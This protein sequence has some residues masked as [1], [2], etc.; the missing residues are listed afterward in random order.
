[1]AHPS[2]TSTNPTNGGL[3]PSAA[4][5]MDS[6]RAKGVGAD[7]AGPATMSAK[8]P[9]APIA[10]VFNGQFLFDDEL[11][12]ANDSAFLR[13]YNLSSED[14]DFP[15]LRQDQFPSALST[16][17]SALDLAPLSQMSPRQHR[18]DPSGGTQSTVS[19]W[20]HTASNE[21]RRNVD[22]SVNDLT[23]S[24][25]ALSI[26]ESHRL[27]PGA[28]RMSR[29]APFSAPGAELFDQE[30]R[31]ARSMGSAAYPPINMRSSTNSSAASSASFVAS[32]PTSVH[33]IST[34][35]VPMLASSSGALNMDSS[36]PRRESSMENAV[37]PVSRFPNAD[38]RLHSRFHSREA[39]PP[40][41][42]SGHST[43]LPNVN[44]AMATPNGQANN[45]RTKPARQ[46]FG[47]DGVH[48]LEDASKRRTD[49]DL[50]TM[51]LENLR[52]ELSQLCKD[53]YGCR[54]LQK[55][56][57]EN[58]RGQCDLIFQETFPYF[59]E[60]MTDPFGNYLCQKLL[61]YCTDAQ[62]DQI[63]AAIADDLVTISLNMH[64]TRAVQKT[65]DFISTPAQTQTIIAALSRNVVT[66]IKDLNGNHVIQK[67]LNRLEAK[68]SQFIYDAVAQKCMDVAT[69]RHG[70]C[71]MQRCIDHATDAQRHQ[72]VHEITRHALSLVQD[73]FG[74][75]VVQY[76][77]D[78]NEAPFTEALTKQFVHHVCLL[79]AQKFSSNVIEKCIRV[80]SPTSRKYLI[81]ELIDETKLEALLRDSFANY[82]VQTSLDY[83]EPAQRT[84]LVN[85]IRPIL[86]A[87]RNTPYGK[88]I[89]SKLQREGTEPGFTNRPPRPNGT[90]S[91][92]MVGGGHGAPV[93]RGHP[94]NLPIGSRGNSHG[95]H[96]HAAP[97]GNR[98]KP[99]YSGYAMPSDTPMYASM[100]LYAP[101]HTMN[102][103]QPR[104]GAPEYVSTPENSIAGR[105]SNKTQW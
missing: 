99:D 38:S 78:L 62:R 26:S 90:Q 29:I 24:A 92:G 3:L 17:S 60:L 50:S 71:V 31:S 13:K 82:V 30:S 52:G 35:G 64:G 14:D 37:D 74:N 87:I 96:L 7:M 69:H 77:L 42:K 85:C 48:P 1:M 73:P 89:Q 81:D 104:S 32:R 18:L 43:Q 75:Y 70:C 97:R 34:L 55:K 39:P 67:C 102:L 49:L 23:N 105:A 98:R 22:P 72:L 91:F 16:F 45:S 41:S 93:Y 51:R 8:A 46:S 103:T 6:L 20:L 80:A 57:E 12:T 40:G 44:N 86:P 76:V 54:F 63:V 2:D 25:E 94:R 95:G 11:E 58:D 19:P 79:S 21:F 61:E 15:V 84:Q 68:D 83:A 66:L 9:G 36:S 28:Q 59:A 10:P 47:T 100:P 56:L 65:I 5:P 33:D 101:V 4:A 88:R 53:Q 27:A